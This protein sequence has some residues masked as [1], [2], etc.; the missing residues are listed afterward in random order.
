MN[1]TTQPTPLENVLRRVHKLLA[2][3]TDDRANAAEAAAAASQA[4]KIMR[5]YQIEHADVIAASLQRDDS[6]DMQDIGGTMNPSAVSKSATTW[7]GMLSLAV[8]RLN[9]CKASWARTPALGMCIRYSGYKSDTQV[10]LW[11]HLYVVNQMVSALRKHQ[12]DHGCDRQ[13]SERFRKGFI[14][15]IVSSINTAIKEKQAEMAQAV[16]S[17]ALVVVKARA[18]AERFGEQTVRQSRFSHS[19]NAFGQGHAAGSQVDMGRRGVSSN[20]SQ[21]IRLG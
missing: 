14:I 17:R 2:I 1:D 6:F 3:A 8:A 18:V 9:D 16:S 11:T 21:A 19:G 5:K 20:A 12:K 4:E 15:A 7:A 10:A 13:D